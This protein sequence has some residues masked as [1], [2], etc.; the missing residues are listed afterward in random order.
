[1]DILTLGKMNQMAKDLDQTME[2]LANTTFET[3]KD[4]C[5]VQAEVIA[6]Q[7]GQ[8]TCLQ[9]EVDIGIDALA[10]AGGGSK[11]FKEF[12]ILNTNHWSVTNGGCCLLWTAPEG[13]KSI[14]FEVLGG[15]GPGGSS[16]RDYDI[17][18]GGWGGNY[19][20][21][22]L[23]EGVDFTA[24]TS[25]FTLC[26]GG[27]SQ[28]SCCAHCQPCRTGCTSWVTGNGLSNFCATGGEGGFT[29]WDKKSSCYDCSIGAQCVVGNQVSGGWGQCQSCTPGF[30]GAD[31]GFTGTT[32]MVQKG[33]SCCNEISGTR[34]GPTGP[35][36]GSQSNG[37]DTNECTTTGMGCCRGH[38]YFPGGGGGGGGFDGGNGCW[39][40]FGA[41]GL[42]KVSYQ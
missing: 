41:G 21:R 25:N 35:F 24:G 30:F 3:L 39:G 5:D 7:T 23:E 13:I 27:T 6:T 11:P 33:Y 42:V 2:Y 8:V 22:T 26:A 12:M 20:A 16:G 34:G 1:M 28:C 32:G 10:A 15:G 31:Y 9:D 29:A 17:P 38:S 40:G 18:S 19:A 37:R 14:K 4:V 36:S